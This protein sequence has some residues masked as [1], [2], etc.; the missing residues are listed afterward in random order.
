MP[1]ASTKAGRFELPRDL[2]IHN[3]RTGEYDQYVIPDSTR[4]S[5]VSRFIYALLARILHYVD[6]WIENGSPSGAYMRGEC[7]RIKRES[8]AHA[9]ELKRRYPEDYARAKRDVEIQFGVKLD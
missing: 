3:S 5:R 6:W 1:S 4:L 2:S 7:E 9:A 8:R